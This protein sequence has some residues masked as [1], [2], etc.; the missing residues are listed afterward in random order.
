MRLAAGARRCRGRRGDD[1]WVGSSPLSFRSLSL[2]PA[3][4]RAK[5]LD[6]AGGIIPSYHCI[7][8]GLVP[9]SCPPPH[10]ASP[11]EE[12]EVGW[13]DGIFHFRHFSFSAFFIFGIFHSRHCFHLAYFFL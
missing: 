10:R 12:I 11:E 8:Y 5:V 2:S 4:E 9:D 1:V 6:G 3:E 7:V 13:A